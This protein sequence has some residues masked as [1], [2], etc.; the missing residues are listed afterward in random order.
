MGFETFGQIGHD[1]ITKV[2]RLKLGFV[3]DSLHKFGGTAFC[4]GSEKVDLLGDF[5][6]YFRSIY[7]AIYNS[8][9]NCFKFLN[10]SGCGYGVFHDGLDGG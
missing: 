2:L 6:G 7:D 10:D 5:E 4:P 8:G 9:W 3:Q 1:D